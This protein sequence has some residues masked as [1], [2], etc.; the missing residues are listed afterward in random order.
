MDRYYKKGEVVNGYSI[1][2]EI[3]EGRY[4]IVY[5]AINDK[6]EK[7]VVKQLKLDMLEVT[8]ENLFY[9]ERILTELNDSK[10][11]KFISKFKDK[12]CEGYLL[13]YVEGIVF[14]DLLVE[15][16]HEFRLFILYRNW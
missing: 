12:Y 13:E 16:G 15:V 9:E 10:F 11:P 2:K 7:C 8:R 6:N 1:I 14:E 4:G 3:G 5:L